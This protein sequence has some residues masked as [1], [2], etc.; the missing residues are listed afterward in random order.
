VPDK[1]PSPAL[2]LV[3]RQVREQIRAIRSYIDEQ[4]GNDPQDDT[5]R[6]A[7]KAILDDL[8]YL[9]QWPW[10]GKVIPGMARNWRQRRAGN[11][12]IVYYYVVD[13]SAKIYLIDLRH[14]SQRPLKPSTIRKYK[15]EIPD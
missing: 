12:Y 9:R 3:R 2:V 11:A 5:G 13:D 8:V 10:T 7:Q 14:P 1:P 15:A 4:R 6:R